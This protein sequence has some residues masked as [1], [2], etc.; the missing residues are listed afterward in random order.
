[1]T[2]KMEYKGNVFEETIEVNYRIKSVVI[3]QK[4]NER[5]NL[6][7]VT[8]IGKQTR[9]LYELLKEMYE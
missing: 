5:N 1:M 8:I 9:D 3:T 7:C 6:D 2:I 4:D